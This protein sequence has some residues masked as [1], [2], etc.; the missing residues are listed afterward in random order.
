LVDARA[1][2][3]AEGP[4]AMV[5]T[6]PVRT[7]RGDGRP[8]RTVLRA[9]LSA[10]AAAVVAGCAGVAAGCGLLG[11]DPPPPPPDPLAPL[12]A[13][14]VALIGRYDT[15][16][17]AHP[18]LA[19]GLDPVRRAHVAHAAELAR[20]VGT[21]APGTA[22]PPAP[23]A[24]TTTPPATPPA[25]GSPPDA[26]GTLAALRAAEQGGRRAAA[27]A[28][29]AAPPERA[30]LLGSIAAARATHAEALR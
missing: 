17:A 16:L 13:G 8:R 11:E 25:T 1:D 5:F 14:T 22:T 19:A 6:V 30:A 9:V 4:A 20:L 2:G 3:D 7:V 10:G 29:L 27:E 23:A 26:R 21:P 12:L 24:G 18:D 15:A 28:C